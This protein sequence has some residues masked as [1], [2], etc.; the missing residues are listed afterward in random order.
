MPTIQLKDVRVCY[1]SRGEGAPPLILVHG[2]AGGAHV[3][4]EQLGPL[5][6]K[7]R[8]VALDL[9]GHGCAGPAPSDPTV[10]LY[11]DTVL[12]LASELKMD[13]F[14]VLGHSM[15]GAVAQQVALAG[16]ERV[17]ALVLAATG[18]RLPVSEA[19]FSIIDEDFDS[20]GSFLAKY[21][22]SRRTDPETVARWTQPPLLAAQTAARADFVACAR[23][24]SRER[25]ESIR[26]PTLV[27]W[28]EDDKM[29]GRKGAQSLANGIP[30][31]VFKEMGSVGHFLFV[32]DPE[33]FNREVDEFLSGVE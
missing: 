12:G 20:F 15:G 6:R 8:V 25:L 22:F 29:V 4:V 31:G 17:S 3:W 27:L 18:A 32:E 19:V 23:F 24:D 11:A 14:A 1:R 26:V 30:G 28:G 16:G 7:R 9:P 13:R 21:A 5:S 33:S 10:E 2:A